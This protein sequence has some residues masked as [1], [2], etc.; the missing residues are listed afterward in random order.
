MRDKDEAVRVMTLH[1]DNQYRTIYSALD[2][3]DT[4][5]RYGRTE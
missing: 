5:D 2:A 1:I 3:R 4:E